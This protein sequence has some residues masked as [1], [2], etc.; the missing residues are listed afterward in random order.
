VQSSIVSWV[1]L[2]DSGGKTV[3]SVL[4]IGIN[5]TFPDFC[6]PSSLAVFLHQHMKPYEDRPE[7]IARGIAY[8]MDPARGGFVLLAHDGAELLGATVVLETKMA[9]YVPE[10]ILL[11]IGVRQDQRGCGLGGE[12]IDRVQ[13]EIRGALKLHVEHDNPALRLYKRK[14]F[15][16]KYLE[17]RWHPKERL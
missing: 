12:M 5:D 9:G 13:N 1:W 2:F 6:D 8:A 7:D 15:E 17:M 14:G 3:A 11:F 10:N 4:K 16:N